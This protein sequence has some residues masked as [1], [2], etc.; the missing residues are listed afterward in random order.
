MEPN[1]TYLIDKIVLSMKPHVKQLAVQNYSG[2]MGKFSS[3]QGLLDWLYETGLFSSFSQQRK[4]SFPLWQKILTSYSTL[5]D[6]NVQKFIYNRA[7]KHNKVLFTRIKTQ[8]FNEAADLKRHCSTL[9]GYSELWHHLIEGAYFELN[10]LI[11]FTDFRKYYI[12][13]CVSFLNLLCNI[14]NK[15]NI[16]PTKDYLDEAAQ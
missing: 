16:I 7:D 5:L 10:Y 13:S 11:Q 2:R 14:S 1:L 4:I 6:M 9:S 15:T 12:D 8:D 3:I